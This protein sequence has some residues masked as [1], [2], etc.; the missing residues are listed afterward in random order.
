MLVGGVAL[1]VASSTRRSPSR[2]LCT[3]LARAQATNGL[4]VIL[5]EPI[6][7]FD[8]EGIEIV[9]TTIRELHSQGRTIIVFS[10]D[11]AAIKGVDVLVDLNSK[12]IPSIGQAPRPIENY[13]ENQ[14]TSGTEYPQ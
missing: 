3:S 6:E 8:K 12:P 14:D 2:V 9:N 5:D 10:H 4:L 13:A 7:G 1:A 11:Q